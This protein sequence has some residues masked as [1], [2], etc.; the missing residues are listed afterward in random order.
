MWY[1]GVGV[2]SLIGG[3][4]YVCGL[5][6]WNFEVIFFIWIILIFN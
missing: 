2:G 1:C 4:G 5:V 6:G 3:I